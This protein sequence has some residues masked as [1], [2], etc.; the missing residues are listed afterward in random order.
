M[1]TASCGVTSGTLVANWSERVL[2]R[3]E[4]VEGR[5]DLVAA[6]AKA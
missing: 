3:N 4:V 2:A 6:L 1:H 5:E